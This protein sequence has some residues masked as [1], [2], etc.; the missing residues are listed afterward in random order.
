[1]RCVATPLYPL[2]LGGRG[3]GEGEKHLGSELEIMM[4]VAQ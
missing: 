2:S 1:M 4:R 3:K